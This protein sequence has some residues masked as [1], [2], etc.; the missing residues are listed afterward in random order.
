MTTEFKVKLISSVTGRIK[1]SHAWAVQIQSLGGEEV[2]I[3]D[4]Y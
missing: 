2:H 1:T 3:I 4:S